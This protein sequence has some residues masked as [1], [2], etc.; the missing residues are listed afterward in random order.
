MMQSNAIASDIDTSGSVSIA[1]ASHVTT[2]YWVLD[3]GASFHVTSDKSKLVACKPITDGTSIHTADGTSCHITHQGYLHSPHFYI[4]D[5]SC[6][7]Q[8][9]MNL[10]SV[11]QIADMNCFVGFDESSCFIQDR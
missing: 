10:L 6:V 7:P 3:S 4:L 11:G 2:P 1:A 5:V 9:S 8:L